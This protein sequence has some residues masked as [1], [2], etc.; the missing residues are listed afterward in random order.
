MKLYI[1][2]EEAVIG[3]E[4]ETGKGE[5]G[6]LVHIDKPHKPSSTGRVYV[7]LYGQSSWAREFFPSVIGGEWRDK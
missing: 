1:K 7:K 4:V 3:M 2:G 5:K 6:E